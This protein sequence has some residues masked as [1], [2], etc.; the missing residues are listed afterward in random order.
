MQSRALRLYVGAMCIG[1]VLALVFMD[2]ESLL[3]LLQVAPEALAG[4]AALIGMGLLS[5]SLT[6]RFDLG[7]KA[8]NSSI[9]FIPLLASAQLFGPAS[10]VVL[11]VVTGTFGEFFVRRKEPIRATFNVAQWTVAAFTAG[12]VFTL[13]GGKP[14]EATLAA[15]DVVHYWPQLLP[16]LLY[17]LTLLSLNHIAVALAIALSQQLRFLDVWVDALGQSGSTLQD[18]LISPIALAVAFLY[19]E[20]KVWGILVVLLPLFF[21][22]HAYV[23]MFQLRAANQD[24]LKALIKAIE[25]RDPYTSG[26]SLRVSHFARRIA[27]KMGLPSSAVE[28]VSHAALLHDIGKIEAVYTDI[29]MKPAELSTEERAIIQSHVTKGDELLRNLSSV[30]EEVIR[31][32]RHHHERLDG[33]GYPDGLAGSAIPLGARIISV[34][35]AVDAMLSDR[36]YRSALPV[37]VVVAQLQENAGTQF[38]PEIVEAV[39]TSDLLSDYADLMRRSRAEGRLATRPALVDPIGLQT[40]QRPVGS[41]VRAIGN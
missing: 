16:F 30:P 21:I 27:E 12:V 41:R 9:T 39:L 38:D 34:C 24:L 22:R 25:T 18:L 8:R 14:L 6:I 4:W 13:C 29:L 26:H 2:W 15:G 19:I 1:A 10:A 20:L 32:V 11:M 35:D 37:S 33:S 23:S 3:R 7:R 28:R 40:R 36:P 5:E 31:S 17:A